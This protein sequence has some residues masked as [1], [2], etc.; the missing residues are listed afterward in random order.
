MET[1]PPEYDSSLKKARRI[2]ILFLAYAIVFPLV[3][4]ILPENGL[5]VDS[6]ISMFSWLLIFLMPTELLLIY[7][8]YHYTCKRFGLDNLQGIAV[9]MYV[10]STIPSIYAF[11]IGFFNS[12]LRL[13]AITIGLM[14]SLTGL[15]LASM[16]LSRRYEDSTAYNLE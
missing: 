1:E 4:F 3:T 12:A 7:G 6:G 10:F 5:T 16:L 15:W 11:I 2:G 13:L 14:F 8:F 9:P